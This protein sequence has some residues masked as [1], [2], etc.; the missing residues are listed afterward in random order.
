MIGKRLP[1]TDR[2]ALRHLEAAHAISAPHLL[3]FGQTLK[4]S[5]NSGHC[6]GGQSQRQDQPETE[7][8]LHASD[9]NARGEGGSH[10]VRKQLAH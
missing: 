8:E 3:R 2:P 5:V 7:T 4:A 10:L 6:A 1:C 9:V